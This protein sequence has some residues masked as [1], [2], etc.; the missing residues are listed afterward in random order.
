MTPSVEPVETTDDPLTAGNT[1]VKEARKLSRR[2]VR[3]ERR[4]FLADGPKARR[5]RPRGGLRRRGL[6]DTRRLR[7]VRRAGGA[8]AAR[9]PGRRPCPRL[10]QRQRDPGRGRRRVLVRRRAAGDGARRRRARRPSLVAIAADVREPGNAGTL[11]RTADALGVDAV[12]LA[13]HSVDLYNPKTVRASVGSVFHLPVAV[14]PDP[15]RAVGA[16]QAA[17]LVVLAADGAGELAA[18]R[19]RR[20]PGPAR[21]PGCSATR[22]GGCPP[23]WPAWPTTGCGSRSAAGPRA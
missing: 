17:G 10:A 1:R 8:G 7:A 9:R 15:G 14:E 20:A 2:S 22:R 16:A 4:L 6:R 23:S 11:V 5:G 21:P 18:R 13:G 12:V 3:A 19:R